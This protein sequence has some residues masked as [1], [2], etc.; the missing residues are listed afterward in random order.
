MLQEIIR[1]HADHKEKLTARL[2]VN[3]SNITMTTDFSGMGTAEMSMR[4]C[5]DA[6]RGAGLANCESGLCIKG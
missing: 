3:A 4:M 1:C 5:L 6:L 2:S